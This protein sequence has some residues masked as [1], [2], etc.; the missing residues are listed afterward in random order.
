MKIRFTKMQGA[1]NDFLVV[2]GEEQDWPALAPALCSR[3]FGVGSDGILVALPS[4][5]AEVCMRMYNPDGSE[6][7]CGNGLRCLALYALRRG[8]VS[9]P[10]FRVETLSGIKQVRVADRGSPEALVTADMGRAQLA[11]TAI[12]A[13]FPGDS[14]LGMPVEVE[15]ERLLVYALSTG[16]AHTVIFEIPDE[17]RFQRLSPALERHLL[18]PERTSVMWTEV[19]GPDRVKLRIWERAAGETMACGTGACAVAV[20]A[21]LTGRTGS[22]VDV[23]SSGG[24]LRVE[25]GEDLAVRLTGPAAFVFEGVW[26]EG[27]I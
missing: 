1:G 25:V 18:F 14:A 27:E 22:C 19:L 24:T 9:R 12:P 10:D 15:G 8:F 4:E 11:P 5:A 16:T 23:I 21:Y 26:P 3:H 6:D 7:E 2:R 13:L 17:Q 20:A